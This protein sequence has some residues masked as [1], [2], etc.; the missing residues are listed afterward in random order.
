MSLVTRCCTLVAVL[1]L[2][3]SVPS[4][5]ISSPEPADLVVREAKIYTVDKATS[6]AQAL[7]V[8]DGRLVFVGSSSDA[9]A[10]IGPKT[11]V[12]SVGGRVVL[13]GLIDAHIHPLTSQI[14]TCAPWMTAS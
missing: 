11:H 12:E 4:V 5:A 13:P 1:A 8:K 10:W 2:G 7:A 9:H 6:I 3:A 14:W